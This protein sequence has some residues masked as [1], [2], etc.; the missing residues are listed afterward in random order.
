MT[1]I[2]NDPSWWPLIVS[3]RYSSYFVVASATAMVYDWALTFGQEIELVWRPRW[4]LVTFLYLAVR[5]AGIPYVVLSTLRVL[6]LVSTTDKVRNII[7]AAINGLAMVVNAILGVVLII[8]LHGM[9]LG[10]SRI[11]MILVVIFVPVVVTCGVMVAIATSHTPGRCP[12][13]GFHGLGLVYNVGSPCTMSCTLD[14][15]K[16]LPWTATTIEYMDHRGLVHGVNE[17]SRGLLC[18]DA[19]SMGYIF[20]GL[21]FFWSLQLFVLG[22]RLILSVREYH[23]KFMPGSDAETGISAI[24]FQ[25]RVH[26]L[27]RSTDRD[28]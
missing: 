17:N 25:E 15:R 12:N 8:R 18:K 6:P 3:F 2:S 9:Y 26:V 23:A 13:H 24:A 1:L 7:Y 19:S 22:P 10:S 28:M 14:C 27:S 20:A 5:Y 11:L 21:E 4:S 16:I